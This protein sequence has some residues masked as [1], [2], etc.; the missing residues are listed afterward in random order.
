MAE[1][2]AL[3][4]IR[5]GVFVATSIALTLVVAFVLMKLDLGGTHQYV[6]QFSTTEGVAGLDVGSDV[7]VGG[8]VAGKVVRLE[9]Q[10][11]EGAR[12]LS[13]IDVVIKMDQRV[14]LYWSK[15][16]PKDSAKVLRV[17]SLLG[18]SA[19]INFVSVGNP[20]A[21]EVKP[22]PE[23]TVKIP[24]LE[25]GGMLAS[26]V[27]P[28]T[29]EK[30]REIIASVSDSAKWLRDTLP[31]EYRENIAPMLTNLNS[32]VATFRG[33]YE[34]WR[35]PIGTTITNAASLVQRAD[36]MLERNEPA[37][38]ES[39]QATLETLRNAKAVTAD[40]REKSMPALQKLLDRGADA[41]QTLAGSLQQVQDA[42]VSDLPTFDL[43]LDDARQMAA[44]L[45]LAAVEV[46]HSPWKLLY[47]PKPGEVAHE[48][49]YDA[50]RSFAMATDDLRAASQGL[51]QAV[52]RMPGRLESDAAFRE[53]VQREVVDAM[54]RY[55]QAQRRLNDVL[56]APAGQGGEAK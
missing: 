54:A 4:G 3:N 47:Q 2:N 31:K 13:G 21:A 9:P 42:L 19:S 18:N 43:F 40:L 36:Q 17:P 23:G 22:M 6:I 52:Q 14:S 1:S 50:A 5:A 7:R 37:I 11:P 15:D 39:V 48:N 33:D 51:Q 55:E 30:T 34:G 44:Q 25:G 28:D 8:L 24:A 49:L 16:Y 46:R 35:K 41:A 32:T 45:K 29:A 20:P 26:L 53:R 12:S 27:G 38:N 10:I 56:N